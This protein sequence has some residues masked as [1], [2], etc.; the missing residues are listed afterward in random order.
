MLTQ[1]RKKEKGKRRNLGLPS[2]ELTRHVELEMS[3]A[4]AHPPL[5]TLLLES[6]GHDASLTL[7]HLSQ[8]SRKARRVPNSM[9]THKHR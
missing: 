9:P 5:E 7:E 2:P 1:K 8:A 4:I 6:N 3:V